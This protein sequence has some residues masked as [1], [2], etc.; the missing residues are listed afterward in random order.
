MTTYTGAVDTLPIAE[1]IEAIYIGYFGRP[2]D[3]GGLA[4]WEQYYVANLAQTGN[5]DVT[6]TNIANYFSTQAETI[7][8]YPELAGSVTSLPLTGPGSITAL[9][10]Q[11][12]INLFGAVNAGASFWINLIHN[13]TVTL[14]S[15]IFQIANGA[16]S[17]VDNTVLLDR[18]QVANEFSAATATAGIAL[19]GNVTTAFITEG[20]D[21]VLSIGANGSNSTADLTDQ[22]AEANAAITAFVANGGTTVVGPGVTFTLTLSQDTF[23]GYGNDTFSAP[24]AANSLGQELSTLQTGDSL[25]ELSPGGVLDATF[26]PV[27]TGATFSFSAFGGTVTIPLQGPNLIS[28]TIDNIGTWNLS[29]AAAGTYVAINGGAY[30]SGLTTLN[31]INSAAF[32]YIRVGVGGPGFQPLNEVVTTIDATNDALH[33][34]LQVEQLASLMTSA[35]AVAVTVNLNNVGSTPTEISQDNPGGYYFNSFEVSDGPNQG[36]INTKDG[37]TSWTVNSTGAANYVYLGTNGS[38][39]ATSVTFT[40]SAP[41]TVWGEGTDWSHVTAINASMMT[42][43]LTLT[44]STYDSGFLSD[45]ASLTSLQGGSGVNMF[46]LSGMT[47]TELKAMTLLDGGVNGS[48]NG[49]TVILANDVLDG[50]TAALPTGLTDF[51]NI[52]DAGDNGPG[53][54]HAGTINWADLGTSATELTFYGSLDHGTLEVDNAPSTFTVNLQDNEF[55]HV[56]WSFNAANDTVGASNSITINFGC[57]L[58]GDS[59]THVDGNWAFTGY[60]SITLDATGAS[61]SS[62]SGNPYEYGIA[63]YGFTATP[64]PGGTIVLDITGGTAGTS[65]DIS[66]GNV[67]TTAPGLDTADVGTTSGT[68]FGVAIDGGSIVGSNTGYLWLGITDATVINDSAGGN[69]TEGEGLYMAGPDSNTAVKLDITGSVVGFNLLQGSLGPLTKGTGG[70][71]AGDFN[72]DAY[73]GAIGAAIINGGTDGDH[74]FDPGGATTINLRRAAPPEMTKFST[75]RSRLVTRNTP[76][77]RSPSP[78]P[79]ATTILAWVWPP[80][81]TSSLLLRQSAPTPTSCSSTSIRGTMEIMS[82]LTI[83]PAPIMGA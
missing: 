66:L 63:S 83:I 55:D 20:R 40:G 51:T 13:G 71:G 62:T 47:L 65:F 80:S 2:A 25:T 14:G 10:D 12:Y 61:Q 11:I 39:A 78:T 17:G 35:A 16:T 44:G 76:V 46:D 72:S 82:D 79:W 60:D 74:I 21:L 22:L 37:V 8:L 53:S 69:S 68:S 38:E 26:N 50:I 7:G 27:I 30:V 48:T 15:A 64:T 58:D 24:L 18:I 73:V 57:A 6:L 4:F 36:W 77:M 9:V 3:A 54:D 34:E 49:S 81:T 45:P 41:L 1:Q 29:A 67:G 23:T 32:S 75:A 70:T 56:W 59:S 31:M 42:G 19:N 5:V 43:N 52:G 28:A 33:G